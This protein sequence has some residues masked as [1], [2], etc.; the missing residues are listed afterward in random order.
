[1]TLV[2]PAYIEHLP[3]W[4]RRAGPFGLETFQWVALP[5]WL[6]AAAGVGVIAGRVARRLLT[7]IAKRFATTKD[8]TLLARLDGP[9][10]WLAVLATAYALTPLWAPP[11]SWQGGIETLLKLGTVVG[12]FWFLMRSVDVASVR[13]SGSGWAQRAASRSLVPLGSRIAKVAVVVL[14]LVTLLSQLGYPV[15]S[16]VAGLGIGGIAVALAAQKTVEN[17]FGA[18]ALG[19]DQPMRIGDFVKIDDFTGTVE[20]L[21]LRSTRIRTLD[22]TIIT[23]PNGKLAE[24]RIESYAARDRLRLAMTLSLVHGT[25]A[26]QMKEV[27]AGIEKL[28]KAQPKVWPDGITVAFKEIASQSLEVEIAAW[29]QTLEWN[30]FSALRQELLL[31]FLQ[32]IE[33]AGTKLAVPT[34]ALVPWSN[35]SPAAPANVKP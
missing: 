15:A 25:T 20:A 2:S 4:L 12:V 21:G 31:G 26:A 22:R 9:I 33:A 7:V 13:V 27:L 10:S 34:R 28:L 3:E 16:L 32:V 19:I 23:I 30:E 14:A 11:P 17:L 24:M 6:L 1:M 18:F 8:D 29:F 5:L 35:G